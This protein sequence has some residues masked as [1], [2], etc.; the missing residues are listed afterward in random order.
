M[1]RSQI[2]WV[3]S[4]CRIAARN[5]TS[6]GGVFRPA[7]VPYQQ[8]T[9]PKA[10]APPSWPADCCLIWLRLGLHNTGKVTAK[11]SIIQYESLL[12]GTFSVTRMTKKMMTM[13]AVGSS[14]HLP[15]SKVS[16]TIGKGSMD[17]GTILFIGG[18]G[19]VIGGGKH[20]CVFRSGK[21]S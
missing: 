18:W 7:D 9:G 15:S 2:D 5:L 14:V 4:M 11:A 13:E 20:Y 12:H 21:K 17:R 10:R 1:T 8:H 19:V 3:P 6:K 16:I